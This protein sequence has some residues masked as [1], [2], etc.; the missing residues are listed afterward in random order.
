MSN[1]VKLN[2]LIDFSDSA[3]LDKGIKAIST[4][5][6]EL[7][8]VVSTLTKDGART[9]KEINGIGESMGK[10]ATNTKEGKDELFK[11]AA[12]FDRNE[13]KLKENNKQIKEY[14]KV[15]RKLEKELADL[16]KAQ[17]GAA[18]STNQLEKAIEK[19]TFATTKEAKE[20]SKVRLET[21][22]INQ[23][24]R[25]QAKLLSSTTG[26]YD[27]LSIQ[28]N[29]AR[30]S[31]KNLAA[32]ERETS[33]EAKDL[34]RDITR[35]DRKLKSVDKTVGQSF[36][37][38][39][40]Y[41][42]SFNGLG[43]SLLAATPIALGAAGAVQLLSEGLRK[44]FTANRD[45]TLE[46]A[47]V[48]G[49][50]QATTEDFNKLK[51]SALDLGGTTQFTATA[52][53]GLQTEFG[54]LGF[55]TKEILNATEATLNLAIATQSD[56]AESAA[57]AG[58]VIRAFGLDASETTRV[59]DVLTESF[60]ASA[61]DISNF[62]ESIKLVAPIAKAA[63]VSLE[64]TTALL[65]KLADAGLQGSIAGTS[66]RNLLGKLTNPTSELAK[67]L[68]FAVKNGDDLVRAFKELQKG[69]IDL[70]KA[71]EL[72][73]ERSK[74]AFLTFVNGIDSIEDFTT[75]LEN[76]DGAAA[77]LADT[78]S[79][80][81]DG[82]VERLESSFENLLLKGGGLNTFF[83]G[84]VQLITL[85]LNK[86]KGLFEP[87]FG[88]FSDLFQELGKLGQAF[89]FFGKDVDLVNLVLNGVTLSLRTAI[90]VLKSI[91]NTITFVSSSFRKLIDISKTS[92]IIF[93]D[94]TGVIS[95]LVNSF[96]F[97]SKLVVS[98]SGKIKGLSE[99]NKLLLDAVTLLILPFITFFDVI[100]NG[101]VFIKSLVT[102]ISNLIP[103]L[104][105]VQ[106][107]LETYSKTAKK[108]IEINKDIAKSTSL[109]KGVMDG[110][111]K[112]V[113]V[114]VDEVTD[115]DRELQPFISSVNRLGEAVKAVTDADLTKLTLDLDRLDDKF[116]KLELDREVNFNATFSADESLVA[117]NFAD[118]E[119]NIEEEI[120]KLQE[121]KNQIPDFEK[122][123]I[124]AEIKRLQLRLK[125]FDIIEEIEERSREN[126][127]SKRSE[128]IR[129]QQIENEEKIFLLNEFVQKKAD[130][131]SEVLRKE[132]VLLEEQ[133][134]LSE[135]AN[136][137]DIIS[138]TKINASNREEV[139]QL[140]ETKKAQVEVSQARIKLIEDE[141]NKLE[142]V[143]ERRV[144]A[145][146]EIRDLRIDSEKLIREQSKL[147]ADQQLRALT[148]ELSLR[149]ELAKIEERNAAK[150]QEATITGI[151][152]SINARFEEQKV[153]AETDQEKK[154]IEE[155]Q[156]KAQLALVG[157]ETF[158]T[159]LK[160]YQAKSEAA[161]S[162]GVDPGLIN[163]TQL[164]LRDASIAITSSILS[165]GFSDGGY[166][167]DGGKYEA[168]GTV[169][170][171]EFVVDKEHTAKYGLNNLS[172]G[173]FDS[174]MGK[175]FS[176]P[177]MNTSYEEIRKSINIQNV[178]TQTNI[179]Y[180]KLASAIGKKM[181]KLKIIEDL[182]GHMSIMRQE[183]SKFT[184]TRFKDRNRA[185]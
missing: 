111:G 56:L 68:G 130:I 166:T 159:S 169:H 77:K 42:S 12:A 144:E 85:F 11:L 175:M 185:L 69:N 116:S 167:G 96:R 46:L 72:T 39:G 63:N 146:V 93:N 121:K 54:K 37:N 6:K 10:L 97:L 117:D 45:F 65:G 75:Q 105:E 179:D 176:I 113:S 141:L 168:A 120:A 163:P 78:I 73:D 164:A 158:L 136:E 123:L 181:P 128:E 51:D 94:L 92:I 114:V 32:S 53:A 38:V 27:R 34:L 134:K 26:A 64:E 67:E 183:G 145:E 7:K 3:S 83:R 50:T 125:N 33:K 162:A 88:A 91:I 184:K 112:S 13:E 31:Y 160:F 14:E 84:G 52:V 43:Q 2:D 59:T 17:R 115:A 147:T 57:V 124:D 95:G 137:L 30:K 108:A 23:E 90:F 48:R 148:T 143:Q 35:L 156:F 18:K 126:I 182:A 177:E 109:T 139:K 118:L 79:D 152:T 165:R 28:L 8:K 15:V 149:K 106:S 129:S 110:F 135:L 98:V 71:T 4:L 1:P 122:P 55:S 60:T 102:E 21:Q 5:N 101:V 19:K 180:E 178:S 161:I 132:E 100:K 44:G 22:K 140:L 127:E 173:S 103:S 76:A 25:E 62:R 40:N 9:Q 142:E 20:V 74:A 24:N 29:K 155:R 41:T 119:K 138:Q 36:R 174:Q 89:N 171:G 104:D 81:L 80:T 58:N 154:K 99:R 16:S 170:K 153:I 87:L 66:L 86:L 150:I 131:N 61:L 133:R 47:K 172:M 107:K 49:I 157:V 82:D 151:E 70:A